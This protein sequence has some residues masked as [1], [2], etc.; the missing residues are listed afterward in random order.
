MEYGLKLLTV[1]KK[2]VPKFVKSGK[3]TDLERVDGDCF[4]PESAVI[5]PP[6]AAAS[7]DKKRDDPEGDD[8]E[9]DSE[10]A[11][12]ASADKKRDDSDGDDQ[13]PDSPPAAAA[14]DAD[15]RMTGGVWL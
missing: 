4:K 8:Q 15:A 11:A 1:K 10:P 7:A 6:A 14:N 9:P 13:A 3:Q 12:A 5:V 2:D